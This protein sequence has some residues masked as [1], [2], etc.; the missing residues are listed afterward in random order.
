MEIIKVKLNSLKEKEEITY[1]DTKQ[2]RVLEKSLRMFGQLQLVVVDKKMNILSGHRIVRAMKY[3]GFEEVVCVVTESDSKLIGVL[4]NNTTFDSKDIAIADIIAECGYSK[5]DLYHSLPFKTYE[6]DAFRMIKD[7]DWS[8][9]E[10]E[11][12]KQQIDLF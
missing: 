11:K 8:Q 9:Y 6:V 1:S 2:Q 3:F 12:D 7:W 5:H 4:L 10:S